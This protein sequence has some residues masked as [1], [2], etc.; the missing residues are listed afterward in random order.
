MYTRYQKNFLNTHPF[1]NTNMEALL[2]ASTAL[3]YTVPG[4]ATQQFRVKFRSSYTAEIFVRY[5]A[6]A[7]LPS[8]NTATTVSNQEMLPLDECRYV[9]GGDTLSFISSGTPALSAQFLLVQD[10]TGM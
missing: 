8:S 9:N 7:A 6:T 10:T 4:N 5:N 1:S 2:A 3:S